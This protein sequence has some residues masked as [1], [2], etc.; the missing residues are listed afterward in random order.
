MSTEIGERR[1]HNIIG[2]VR[3]MKKEDICRR[4]QQLNNLCQE[5]NLKNLSERIESQLRLI[6]EPL[7]IMIVGEG[8][9][10]KSSLLNA[11]VGS[12]VAEVDYVPKT[13]CIGVYAST[14]GEPYAEVVYQDN[15]VRTTVEEA[16]ELT[17]KQNH[18]VK[19]TVAYNN[20][21]VE[22][23]K[24]ESTQFE[25][26]DLLVQNNKDKIQDLFSSMCQLN[27]MIADINKLLH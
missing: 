5:Y 4:L 12:T 9:S 16:N 26:I 3:Y 17:N 14:K 25:Q 13:W 1:N 22:N 8:K 2:D 7:R 18:W 15:I 19:E 23:V 11:L 10:G 6:D 24:E 27:E 21:V 20:T